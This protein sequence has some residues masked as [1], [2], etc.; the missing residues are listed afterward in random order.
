MLARAGV[1]GVVGNVMQCGEMAIG[2]VA[3]RRQEH[4]MAQCRSQMEVQ[5]RAG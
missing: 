3:V 5:A 4:V 1:D 2:R